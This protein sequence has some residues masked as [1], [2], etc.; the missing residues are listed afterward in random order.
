MFQERTEHEDAITVFSRW[1]VV[2][3]SVPAF[4]VSTPFVQRDKRFYNQAP[5]QFAL[6]ES[7]QELTKGDAQ[8]SDSRPVLD[9]NEEGIAPS[10][11]RLAW[12]TQNT[13]MEITREE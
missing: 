12:K 2:L 5:R 8:F 10:S 7:L 11:K 6:R 13:Y 4:G 1:I 3:V 9:S